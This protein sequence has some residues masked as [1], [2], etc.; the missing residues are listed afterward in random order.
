MKSNDILMYAVKNITKR[1]LRSWLTIIGMVIG[2]I[3]IVVILSIS[4]GFNQDILTQLSAF[5]ADQIIVMPVSSLEGS[6]GGSGV[7]SAPTS[8][9]ILEEDVDDIRSIPGV[10]TVVRT[11]YGRASLSFK[12]K[13]ITATIYPTDV[14]M[15]DMYE[16]YMELES[17]RMY[18]EGER[19]VAV[20]AADASTELFGKDKVSV[21]S[22][23]QLNEKNYR[24]VGVLKKIGTSLSQTDDKAIYV[25]FEDGKDLFKGQ[26]LDD[27]IGYA[28][29]QINE[30]FEANQIKDAIEQK[31][32]ANHH[33]REDEK[34]FSVITSDQIMEMVSSVLL[35][36]QIVLGA[37]TLI[38][39]VVGAIGISN[40]MF[41]NVLERV[42]EIGIL[43][44][45]GAT[46]KDIL[47]LFLTE[48]AIIGLIGGS[49]GLMLGY[50]LLELLVS[51]FDVP[52]LLT[53]NIIA[54]VF[55]FSVGTGLVAGFLPAYRAAKL[56]PVE[57][58]R[59]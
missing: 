48:S 39:S 18:K 13:D 31:L 23:V 12:G 42:K 5:G 19:N 3:A 41:M 11:L 6:F 16:G 22:V 54:F 36:S 20:F 7:G 58:L 57:A 40:T 33:V 29:V 27:E 45:V 55:L 56:D 49:I 38:S 30:G 28:M 17:G 1:Q 26:F 53:V 59:L 37:I 25:P 50:G 8:G 14:A 4:E 44:S 47:S 2:V 32:I 24:V 52:A 9:K 10:K 35:T 21:G 34:D 46:R 51:I 15:F 43:K